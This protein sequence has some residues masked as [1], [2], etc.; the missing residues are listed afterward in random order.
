MNSQISFSNEEKKEILSTPKFHKN[1]SIYSLERD[2]ATLDNI[3]QNINSIINIEKL[4]NEI[5]SNKNIEYI[6][7]VN[8]TKNMCKSSLLKKINSK[9]EV[10]NSYSNQFS[11]DEKSENYIFSKKE[12]DNNKENIDNNIIII[13][14]NNKNNKNQNRETCN[15]EM[16]YKSDVD[17]YLINSNLKN[18]NEN[19]EN[20]FNYILPLESDKS[21]EHF[22]FISF[23]GFSEENQ[24][25]N[26]I[27]KEQK[28]PNQ[29]K[30]AGENKKFNNLEIINKK[31]RIGY[32]FKQRENPEKKMLK[33][34]VKLTPHKK[35]K[36]NKLEKYKVNN[37]DNPNHIIRK[38]KNSKSN[39]Y[40]SKKKRKISIKIPNLIDENKNDKCLTEPN[41]LIDLN[42]SKKNTFF[43]SNDNNLNN[44]NMTP[45]NE[46]ELKNITQPFIIEKITNN[47]NNNND[48]NNISNQKEIE[49]NIIKEISLHFNKIS[50]KKGNSIDFQRNNKFIESNKNIIY[51][52]NFIGKENK[53]FS[54]KKKKEKNNLIHSRN[55]SQLS[56]SN[57]FTYDHSRIK[58]KIKNCVF[59][60]QQ[61][62]KDNSN[63]QTRNNSYG[64]QSISASDSSTHKTIKIIK[65]EKKKIS[66]PFCK[67][68]ILKNNSLLTKYIFNNQSSSVENRNMTNITLNIN[69]EQYEDNNTFISSNKYKNNDKFT[70][71]CNY[72][73]KLNKK[74]SSKEIENDYG[75]NK[76]KVNIANKNNAKSKKLYQNT[77]FMNYKINKPHYLIEKKKGNITDRYKDSNTEKY[78]DSITYKDSTTE[79][80]KDSITYKDSLTERYKE[81][82]T[83][84]DS[85][86]GPANIYTK[87]FIF[88][89]N[90][91]SNTNLYS[92][93]N[94]ETNNSVKIKKD[95]K[96]GD[97][98]ILNK[99]TIIEKEIKFPKNELHNHNNNVLIKD[100]NKFREYFKD[101]LSNIN[102]NKNIRNKKH[103]INFFKN[104]KIKHRNNLTNSNNYSQTE[105]DITKINSF[106]TKIKYKKNNSKNADKINKQYNTINNSI[107]LGNNNK[108]RENTKIS[109][110]KSKIAISRENSLNIPNFRKNIVK[111]SIIRNNQ[112]NE[113][114]NEV[115]IYIGDQNNNNDEQNLEKPN[116][117]FTKKKKGK[118]SID[119]NKLKAINVNKKTIINVNQFY[120]SYFINNNPNIFKNKNNMTSFA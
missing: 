43:T 49:N 104:I 58:K 68:K 21:S 52:K 22:K 53:S 70:I 44:S 87:K 7:N 16:K 56:S 85:Y 27:I 93:I 24:D 91:N 40:S 6:N 116:I 34:D 111:Y 88:S 115:S 30:M 67:S 8:E 81:T 3:K 64:N 105:K 109:T 38:I 99:S 13:D 92:K 54:I 75:I 61:K 108:F 36:N 12:I 71:F 48:D 102:L 74:N 82:I 46:N 9:N 97:T 94:N 113:V 59:L 66:S 86:I 2:E 55:Y 80:Y 77:S 69:N 118:F 10:N 14:N 112:N 17:S 18:N 32:L 95:I 37:S 15:N 25:N 51:E 117:E 57:N 1:K 114:R 76:I 84:K 78:K 28:I 5:I 119:N 62:N 63:F 47:I 29:K 20:N 98:K 65:E 110:K 79:K 45:K 4:N 41:L 35:N 90:N 26:N 89:N 39:Y 11:F 96:K 106:K 101:I 120:P 83:Y 23:Q 107:N 33:E 50:H 19:M 73:S 42:N 100:K 60:L 103:K 72:D 31:I